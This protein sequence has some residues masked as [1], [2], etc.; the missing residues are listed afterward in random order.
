MTQTLFLLCTSRFP[1]P[2]LVKKQRRSSEVGWNMAHC[3]TAHYLP[4]HKVLHWL[5]KIKGE[6]LDLVQENVSTGTLSL[7]QVKHLGQ[8]GHWPGVSILPEHP[9]HD[10]QIHRTQA[11]AVKTTDMLVS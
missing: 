9:Q 4:C 6:R 2:W 1:L 3:V 10:T 8:P 5:Q 11:E 7:E